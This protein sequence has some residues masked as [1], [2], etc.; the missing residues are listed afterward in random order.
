ML[1]TMWIVVL[2]LGF[3][4]GGY[5]G[6]RRWGSIVGNRIAEGVLFVLAVFYLALDSVFPFKKVIN[7]RSK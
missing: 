2:L 6:Y 1:T 7:D 4:A 5:Y 3:G